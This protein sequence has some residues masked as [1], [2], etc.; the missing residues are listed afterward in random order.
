MILLGLHDR[1]GQ[2]DFAS[3][4]VQRSAATGLRSPDGIL[5]KTTMVSPDQR[6]VIDRLP[7]VPH[8]RSDAFKLHLRIVHSELGYECP[9]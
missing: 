6:I 1:I 5:Q 4:V 8:F 2:F 7:G 9:T 3:G